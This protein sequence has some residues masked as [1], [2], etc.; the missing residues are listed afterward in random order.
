MTWIESIDE[1]DASGDLK[2]IYEEI[3]QKRGKLSNIM[4]VQSLH[5]E[6]M[7]K[8]MDLYLSI[9][10]GPSELSREDRELIAVTVS[11]MN[12][13]SY[14]INHHAE[15]LRSFWKDEEKIS[16]L[17]KDPPSV[18]ISLRQ[19]RLIAYAMKLT[20]TPS[21]MT[22]QDVEI[23]RN[24]GFSDKVILDITPIVSY[25]NFVN[26]IALGLGVEFS[27]EEMKGYSYS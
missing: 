20:K 7:Q 15:A 10:F 24:H 14:C 25:F 6:V 19:Q 12:N 9:M 4:K 2:I 16:D 26:R 3:I 23:L 22:K 5:P 18:H 1:I 8:H 11:V 21:S 13:C 17:I 27:E